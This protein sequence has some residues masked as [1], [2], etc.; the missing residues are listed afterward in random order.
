MHLHHDVHNLAYVTNTNNALA[1][2]PSAA[3]D[4]TLLGLNH[5]VG[6]DAFGST[7][8]ATAIRCVLQARL[9]LVV[10]A[11]WPD[12][13]GVSACSQK[14]TGRLL[15]ER[16]G[17]ACLDLPAC[18]RSRPLL[19]TISGDPGSGSAILGG[20]QLVLHSREAD[21]RARGSNNAGG[22][23]NH[24][25]YFKCM[26]PPMGNASANAP[27]ADSALSKAIDATW[28][29]FTAFKANFTETGV[30]RF[31]SGFAWLIV[32]PSRNNALVT[33][34]TPNQARAAPGSNACAFSAQSRVARQR[35]SHAGGCAL[36]AGDHCQAVWPHACS[37]TGACVEGG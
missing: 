6:T 13:Q 31:G 34:S 15:W 8:R 7:A 21:M 3:K 23:W 11:V 33:L 28:G 37:V 14:P 1:T 25:F 17:S 18:R 12:H 20:Q 9:P 32:S 22:A 19:S 35:L 26:A 16:P 24:A 36:L 2:A 4:L 29:N 30:T 10:R 5:Y 27:S